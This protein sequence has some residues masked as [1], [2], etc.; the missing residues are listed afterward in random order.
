LVKLAVD[1]ICSFSIV[2]LRAASVV[3]LFAIAVSLAFA[4]YAVYVRIV[5][6][7][8]PAGFTASLLIMTFLAGVQLL[9]LG[10]IGEYLG[11]VYGE[12]KGRPSYVVA[13]ITGAE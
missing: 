4:L 11:R 1:G 9:F 6:G 2:P 13:K 5:V 7:H 10:V 8:V 12:A 3:G